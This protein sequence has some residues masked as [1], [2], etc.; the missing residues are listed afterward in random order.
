[1]NKKLILPAISD[2]TADD[3]AF[4]DFVRRQDDP[5]REFS[6]Y[7]PRT[8]LDDDAMRKLHDDDEIELIVEADR[9]RGAE[10]GICL[11]IVDPS[12]YVTPEVELQE[13]DRMVG[14]FA[15]RQEGEEPRLSVYV[16]R[17]GRKTPVT[18][19]EIVMYHRSIL[20]KDATSQKPWEVISKNGTILSKPAPISS[21]AHIANYFDLDG[22]TKRESVGAKEFLDQLATSLKHEARYAMTAPKGILHDSFRIDLGAHVPGRT[23]LSD[24]YNALVSNALEAE[25]S[26]HDYERDAIFDQIFTVVPGP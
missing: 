6:G 9:R 2:I 3:I 1:M 24:E 22:G 26:L 19:M 14:L 10:P 4:N 11:A 18:T 8:A 17:G 23:Y 25:E 20:G 12:L 21:S 16:D 13:G 5:A 15:A 7:G